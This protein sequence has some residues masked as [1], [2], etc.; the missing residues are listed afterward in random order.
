MRKKNRSSRFCNSNNKNIH[1]R[2]GEGG[3]PWESSVELHGFQWARFTFH[4]NVSECV[5]LSYR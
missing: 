3:G 2:T 1:E 5:V 4:A